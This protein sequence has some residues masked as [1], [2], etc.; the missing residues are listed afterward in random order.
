MLKKSETQKGFTFVEVIVGTAVFVI[1]ALSVYSIFSL[2]LKWV[3]TMKARVEASSIAAEK[4]ETIRNMP[5]DDIKTTLGWIPPGVIPSTQTVSRSNINFQVD[6]TISYVNDLFDGTSM[7]STPPDTYP[8]DYKKVEVKVSWPALLGNRKPVVF[9]TLVVPNGLEGMTAG[10]GGIWLKVFDASGNGIQGADV[11]VENTNLDPDYIIDTTTD[12]N[13]YVFLTDLDPDNQNYGVRVSKANYSSERTYSVAELAALGYPG[14]VPANYPLSVIVGQVTEA[15]FA[16]D[17]LSSLTINTVN[18]NI[19]SEFK[20]SSDAGNAVQ[21][22]PHLAIDSADKMYFVWRDLRSGQRSYGQKYN[23]GKMK[24]WPSSDVQFDSRNNQTNP[25][26]VMA[27]DGNI[28]VAWNDSDN[29]NQD[30]YL[31]KYS[32]DNGTDLWG[33]SKKVDMSPGASNADQI[34]PDIDVDSVGNIVVSWVDFRNGNSD[35]DIYLKKID[36]SGISAWAS[37]IKVN[38]DVDG[39][40][41]QSDS[42]V[43]I[44][45][46]SNNIYVLWS[47]NRNG[48]WDIYMNKFDPNG[49]KLWG[50]DIKVNTDT[51]TANQSFPDVVLDN[52]SSNLYVVWT[53]DRNVNSDIY[54]QKYD[55]NGVRVSTGV[56]VGGDLKVNSDTTTTKQDN[57]SIAIDGGNNIYV[58]WTD[59]RNPSA[60]P[61]IYLQKFNSDGGIIWNPDVRIN[62]DIA[63]NTQS[64]PQIK[65]LSDGRPVIAWQDERSG[66]SDI[67]AAIYLEPNPDVRGNVPIKTFIT[68]QIGTD[69]ALNP[70]YK[71]VNNSTTDVNGTLILNNIEWGNYN[72]EVTGGL[73][74]LIGTTP[75]QPVNL[76]PNSILTVRVNVDP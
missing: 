20:V 66:N 54:A 23:V 42:I 19:P 25:R 61:D 62:S 56:W 14:A 22:L 64:N 18:E 5:Y 2:S 75:L 36:A 50:S 30:I 41:S 44:D 6:T 10:K 49:V 71:Y 24:Q 16:I 9:N 72:I 53:D 73:Y 57:P 74:T 40:Y 76:N 12:F 33:G 39:V 63:Q 13:G 1:V 32:E 70:I 45:P 21:E 7:A 15:S 67:Y 4:I 37:E 31:D 48:N 60:G 68:K 58:T 43:V 8:W 51:G 52:T 59:E 46:I 35:P 69:A 65:I 11:H 29:G 38:S 55:S 26:V 47:D 28:Y 3:G 27:L 34:K 17:L